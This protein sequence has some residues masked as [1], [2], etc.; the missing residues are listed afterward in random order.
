V[1]RIAGLLA[2]A[3][4]PLLSGVS[5]TSGQLG[6]GFSRAMLIAAGTCAAGGLIAWATIPPRHTSDLQ[7]P[8]LAARQSQESRQPLLRRPCRARTA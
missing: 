4:L 1:A 6:P 2:V 5:S 7:S 3:V 8:G